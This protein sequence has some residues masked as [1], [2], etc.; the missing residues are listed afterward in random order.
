MCY[1]PNGTAPY[2]VG[3]DKLAGYTLTDVQTKPFGVSYSGA[4][5]K[6]T[7]LDTVGKRSAAQG[8]QVS[9]ISH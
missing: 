4:T 6:Y 2:Q 9:A 3:A 7:V 1:G 5:Y 8:G